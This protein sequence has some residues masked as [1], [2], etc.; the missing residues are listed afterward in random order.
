MVDIADGPRTPRVDLWV[1]FDDA[2]HATALGKCVLAQLDEDTRRDY[3][4][5]HPLVDLTPNTITEPQRLLQ[6][7]SRELSLDQEEY[8]IGTSCIAVPVTDIT[9]SVIGALAISCRANRLKKVQVNVPVIRATAERI[10]RTL[11]L[12]SM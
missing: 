9:G 10:N 4:A 3:L 8:A 7:L 11:S 6:Q 1:G 2:A 12:H 5:R